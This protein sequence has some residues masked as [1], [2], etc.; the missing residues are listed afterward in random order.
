MSKVPEKSDEDL[1]AEFYRLKK[2]CS[3][4]IRRLAREKKVLKSESQMLRQRYEGMLRNY[5]D[6]KKKVEH[7]LRTYPHLLK[8]ISQDSNVSLSSGSQSVQDNRKDKEIESLRKNNERLLRM[9]K[10]I[11][12]HH[13]EVF[14]ETGEITRAQGRT[15]MPDPR[16]R[17]VETVTIRT[18]VK[19]QGSLNTKRVPQSEED[20]KLKQR[21]DRI[22]P[23]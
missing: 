18:E 6:F 15:G 4:E 22:I 21:L 13:P 12:D 14:K 3:E 9:L 1:Q 8:E 16:F 23:D 10:E 17:P 11:K 7:V 20:T 2:N 19:H 5:F